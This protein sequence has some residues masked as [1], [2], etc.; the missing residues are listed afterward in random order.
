MLQ[1]VTGSGI[2]LHPPIPSFLEIHIVFLLKEM[3]LHCLTQLV[4]SLSRC[5]INL[6]FAS[7]S[8]M[9]APCSGHPSLSLHQIG[10]TEQIVTS[11]GS[12]PTGKLWRFSSAQEREYREET[13][14]TETVKNSNGNPF[15]SLY[16]SNDKHFVSFLNQ[17]PEIE[18]IWCTILLLDVDKEGFNP[19]PDKFY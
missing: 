14:V 10:S 9:S 18:C 13:S 15:Q 6:M 16:Q 4:M 3:Q 2:Y 5:L 11:H 19:C 12:R 8:S 17:R 7:S 1:R